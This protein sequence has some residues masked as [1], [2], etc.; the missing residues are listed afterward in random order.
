MNL[1]ARQDSAEGGAAAG[2]A[3]PRPIRSFVRREG[4]ITPAQEQALERLWPR[5][6]VDHAG[7]PLL[8][9]ELFGR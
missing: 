1:G 2:A 3:A 5:Y 9:Q 4:R 6:G 7:A 8:P